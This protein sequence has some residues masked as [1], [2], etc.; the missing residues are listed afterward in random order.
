L[1]EERFLE[2]VDEALA[3]VPAEFASYLDN[4]EVAVEQY[5]SLELLRSMKL[6][7]THTLLG[8]YRGVPFTKRGKSWS[9]LFPDQ[10]IIFQ[11]PIEMVCRGDEARIIRQVGKT[12]VHEIGHFFGIPDKRLRELGY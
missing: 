1:T 8:V 12:V 3:E 2:L 7:A 10:I 5:P 4:V 6:P 11:K 9:P